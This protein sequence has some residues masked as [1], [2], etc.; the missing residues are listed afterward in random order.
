MTGTG[1]SL[2]TRLRWP[3]AWREFAGFMRRPA[4]PGAVTGITRSAVR[5]VLLLLALDALASAAILALFFALEAA[6][7]DLPDSALTEEDF[8]PVL[9]G[10]MVVFAPLLEEVLFRSWLTGRPAAW[11]VIKYGVAA[12]ALTGLA[13]GFAGPLAGV[14]VA[15][16][17]LA[18]AG[19]EYWQRRG[20]ATAAWYIR[21]FPYF[22]FGSALAFSAAHLLNYGEDGGGLPTL[23]VV[24][25]FVGGLIL[26]YARVTYGLW[27]SVA[28][29]AAFN[30]L[31]VLLVLLGERLG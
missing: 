20:R 1:S 22:Y 16:V 14:A 7:I 2:T 21:R 30:G 15:I 29:H 27:A 24:P 17:L 9:I 11:T 5:P 4:L 13:V 23:M 12:A 26:G 10:L 18:L 25:Q 19:R 8:T 28:M 31:L 3:R 6:G